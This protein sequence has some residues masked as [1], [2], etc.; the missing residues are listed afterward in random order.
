VGG[1][2]KP[3]GCFDGPYSETVDRLVSIR[4]DEHADEPALRGYL[5]MRRDA[6]G[7]DVFPEVVRRARRM[8]PPRSRRAA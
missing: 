2:L 1:L 8:A 4:C 5:L 7:R 6:D 3:C